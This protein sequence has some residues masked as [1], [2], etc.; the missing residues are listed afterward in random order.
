[1]MAYAPH[2]PSSW[3]S[4]VSAPQR[5]ACCLMDGVGNQQRVG[6]PGVRGRQVRGRD[7]EPGSLQWGLGA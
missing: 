3:G 2:F 4:S 5:H 1:M 6:L 7:P